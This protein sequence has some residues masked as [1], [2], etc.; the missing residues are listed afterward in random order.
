MLAKTWA[1]VMILRIY[2]LSTLIISIDFMIN[3]AVKLV[4]SLSHRMLL[5]FYRS[6]MKIRIQWLFAPIR[7]R[8]VHRST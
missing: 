8:K 1:L 3:V 4:K 7:L 2:P 6:T 5:G